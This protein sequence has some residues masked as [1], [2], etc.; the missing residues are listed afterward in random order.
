MLAVACRLCCWLSEKGAHPRPIQVE[1]TKLPSSSVTSLTAEGGRVPRGIGTH[2]LWQGQPGASVVP[3]AACGA[4]Q[5]PRALGH[6]GQARCG[7][8]VNGVRRRV[9]QLWA[10]LGS[11]GPPILGRQTGTRQP[12]VGYAWRTLRGGGDWRVLGHPRLKGPLVVGPGVSSIVHSCG[13]LLPM[14]GGPGKPTSDRTGAAQTV[15]PKL[16]SD[17]LCLCHPAWPCH[18][19]HLSDPRHP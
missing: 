9:R 14:A 10:A 8:A 6:V 7:S 1:Q 13:V 12:L 18:A 11:F 3:G 16:C 4:V 17:P 15:Q 5:H 19:S 2:S